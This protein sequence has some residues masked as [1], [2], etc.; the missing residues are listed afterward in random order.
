MNAGT[1]G[2]VGLFCGHA[3]QPWGRRADPGP[4]GT[5]VTPADA[6]GVWWLLAMVGGTS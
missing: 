1:L 5:V 4:I 3:L 6:A 2:P